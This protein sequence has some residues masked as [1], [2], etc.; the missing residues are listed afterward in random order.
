DVPDLVE[1]WTYLA[2]VPWS[3]RKTFTNGA[4]RT[5]TYFYDEEEATGG[6]LNGDGRTDQAAGQLVKIAHPT[7][8]L[9]V[10]TPQTIEEKLWYDARGRLLRRVDPQNRAT[11]Y[12]YFTAGPEAGYMARTI[13]D[14]GGLDLTTSWTV[15]RVGNT[16]T[17]TS[18]R[19]V[20][21]SYEVD[22]ADRVTRVNG[23]LGY[24]TETTYQGL[25]MASTRVKNLLGDGQQDPGLPW[26]V[27]DY[28]HTLLG[29][30]AT[31][32]RSVTGTATAT[33]T[34]TRDAEQNVREIAHPTGRRD[35]FEHDARHL[36]TGVTQGAGSASAVVRNLWYD[37]NGFKTL[38]GWASGNIAFG[39]DV[40]TRPTGR[41]MGK[42]LAKFS[43][44]P[45]DEPMPGAEEECCEAG[46]GC[47]GNGG[48]PLP[49]VGAWYAETSQIE[50]GNGIHCE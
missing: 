4:G 10:T 15:D 43:Y 47:G 37:D 11:V 12:E 36:P 13:E 16:L 7:V 27:T 42:Y 46:G 33:T 29:E 17:E 49:E 50:E 28:T 22:R 18:P 2:G 21:T 5:T 1:S 3:L 44:D 32:T 48:T 31:E 35:T 6:D 26:I 19:Q 38:E 39:Y 14:A 40:F 45:P 8:T 41:A 25:R 34:Y 23:P 24:T 30:V 9:G 20:T